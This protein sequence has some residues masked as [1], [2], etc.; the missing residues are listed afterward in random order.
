MDPSLPPAQLHA[1]TITYRKPNRPL[2]LLLQ[3]TG[4]TSPGSNRKNHLSPA[5]AHPTWSPRIVQM[6][7]PFLC[8]PWRNPRLLTAHSSCPTTPPS[9]HLPSSEPVDWTANE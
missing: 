5:T 7:V 2:T 4:T 6:P 8:R 1:Y 9:L 3:T